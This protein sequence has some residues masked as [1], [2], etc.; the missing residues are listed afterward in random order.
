VPFAS[1]EMVSWLMMEYLGVSMGM[2]WFYHSHPVSK[3]QF[4][5]LLRFN[6]AILFG[7]EV[8]C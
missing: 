7:C 5:D 4:H 1:F 8:R 2:S 3:Y 6:R